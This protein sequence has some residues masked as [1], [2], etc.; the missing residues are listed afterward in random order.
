[1][2]SSIEYSNER[3]L[4]FACSGS[5]DVGAIADGTARKLAHGNFGKMTCLAGLAGR[6]PDVMDKIQNAHKILVIDGCQ[7][8]CAAKCLIEAG[9]I[10][11]KH[12]RLHDLGFMKDHCQVTD[13]N[14]SSSAAIGAVLLFE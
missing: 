13:E 9:I 8:H 10:H 6:V 4:I 12:L 5:S 3:K 11:L 7:Q 1:M 14:I 2:A